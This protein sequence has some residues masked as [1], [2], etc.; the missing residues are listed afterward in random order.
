MLQNIKPLNGIK[1]ALRRL[2]TSCAGLPPA[3]SRLGLFGPGGRS[4]A[5]T[6]LAGAVIG[7]ALDR[8]H[9]GTYAWTLTLLAAGL[10]LGCCTVWLWAAREAAARRMDSEDGDA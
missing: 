5:A 7:L 9:P 10:T 6:T 4:V 2:R 3:F 1:L 8:R